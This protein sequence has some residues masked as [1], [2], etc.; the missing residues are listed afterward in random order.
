MRLK[1]AWAAISRSGSMATGWEGKAEVTLELEIFFPCISEP[2]NNITF[3][4]MF[5]QQQNYLRTYI[6]RFPHSLDK[7]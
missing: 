6:E 5:N 3:D 2:A 1:K 4:E 7:V